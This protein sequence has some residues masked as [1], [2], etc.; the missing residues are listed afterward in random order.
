MASV[1][2]EGSIEYKISLKC[3]TKADLLMNE[4]QTLII[5]IITISKRFSNHQISVKR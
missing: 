1:E 4:Q 2:S 5:I 3:S